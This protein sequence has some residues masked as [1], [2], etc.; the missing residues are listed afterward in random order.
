[1]VDGAHP[2][3]LPPTR[4]ICE[5][6][7]RV[8]GLVKLPNPGAVTALDLVGLDC[9]TSALR[10]GIPT[11]SYRVF[12]VDQIWG[13]GR[14]FVD[15]AWVRVARG[16]RGGRGLCL[17][18]TPGAQVGPVECGEVGFACSRPVDAVGSDLK[19][20]LK[21]LYLRAVFLPGVFLQQGGLLARRVLACLGCGRCGVLD[22]FACL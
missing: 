9:G 4:H 3:T 7:V 21:V 10:G 12:T 22:D 6:S 18:D 2:E 5:I 14:R 19:D 16:C 20:P 13:T 11:D 17:W 1:M 15:L 8:V